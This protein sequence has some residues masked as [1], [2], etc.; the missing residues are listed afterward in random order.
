LISE[1]LAVAPWTPDP[2]DG[3]MIGVE[4]HVETKVAPVVWVEGGDRRR[5]RPVPSSVS[6]R[7][8]STSTLRLDNATNAVYHNRLNYIKDLVP[9]T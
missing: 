2:A 6:G 5:A 7:S 4:S 3:R 1:A 8:A 9:E